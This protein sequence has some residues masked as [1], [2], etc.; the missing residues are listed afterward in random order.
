MYRVCWNWVHPTSC[1]V[2]SSVWL[3]SIDFI[4]ALFSFKTL[5]L[6][7]QAV[8]ILLGIHFPG[9]YQLSY[10]LF[11]SLQ[12]KI[13]LPCAFSGNSFYYLFT[14]SNGSYS[15]VLKHDQVSPIKRKKKIVPAT[16][17]KRSSLESISSLS[18]LFLQSHFWKTLVHTTVVISSPPTV[19]C[20]KHSGLASI[21]FLKHLSLRS[22]RNSKP[23]NKMDTGQAIY[24]VKFGSI[25]YSLPLAH[26]RNS[27]FPWTPWPST[28]LS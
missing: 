9:A 18:L 1:A 22:P 10:F 13:S 2:A 24:N 26:S 3:Q 25:W 7:Y 4:Y 15:Q 23:S 20:W 28:L 6:F 27:Y 12:F 5:C 16:A 19:K 21:T 11:A 8:G 14:L 17:T